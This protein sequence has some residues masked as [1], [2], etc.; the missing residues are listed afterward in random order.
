[1]ATGDHTA[2]LAHLLAERERI[3]EAALAPTTRRGYRYDWAAFE[4]WCRGEQLQAFPASPETVQLYVTAAL[5]RHKISTIVR[6]IAAVN[7]MHRA[8]REPSPVTPALRDLLMC[9]RR[10]RSQ[11]LRQV[12]PLAIDELRR[13]SAI[14]GGRT[15]QAA[16]RDRALMVV[17]FCSALRA[18]SLATLMLA[19][20]EFT[21]R[22]AVLRIR[23]EKQDQAGK[24]RLIGLPPGKDINTCPVRVLLH[25]IAV[26]GQEAG[27]LFSRLIGRIEEP[28]TPERIC[29]IVQ[30]CVALVGLDRKLYGSHS[31]RA[32]L[33]TECGEAGVGELLIASQTGHRD[34]STLRRYFRR[35]DLFK[36]NAI[37]A[38]D[39]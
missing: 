7:Q 11:S 17:G 23:R 24:G 25:W 2:R 10:L 26:R 39:L 18:S 12:R 33:I 3:L 8:N 22:G 5:D 36:A 6:R 37:D 9:A 14:L 30:D 34:M 31:L 20:V 13:I 1:M 27:A 19:D 15:T 32:G 29:N 35:R 28:L 16:A 4:T 38:L 21:A